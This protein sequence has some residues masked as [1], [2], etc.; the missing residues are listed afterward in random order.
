MRGRVKQGA[1]Y[2][3]LCP[4]VPSS[5]SVEYMHLLLYCINYNVIYISASRDFCERTRPIYGLQQGPHEYDL[6]ITCIFL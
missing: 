6:S 4:L 2:L 1:K 3:A 5:P